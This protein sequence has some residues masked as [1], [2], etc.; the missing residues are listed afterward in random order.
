[1]C[2]RTLSTYVYGSPQIY[3]HCLGDG[4]ALGWLAATIASRSKFLDRDPVR[5]VVVGP[6]PYASL[7]FEADPTLES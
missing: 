3:R 7:A 1:M 4:R 5:V 2:V 6:R